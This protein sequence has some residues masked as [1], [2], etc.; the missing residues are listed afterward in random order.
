MVG[1]RLVA[2]GGPTQRSKSC[3]VLDREPYRYQ[4]F[5]SDIAG[6]DIEALSDDPRRAMQR[7]RDWLSNAS[8]RSAVPGHLRNW[9]HYERLL[10]DLPVIR[11]ELGHELEEIPFIDYSEIV[12]DWLAENAPRG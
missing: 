3:L 4:Q 2:Y 7:V 12:L 1:G 5:L 11:D 9:R 6:Q 10:E 8:R